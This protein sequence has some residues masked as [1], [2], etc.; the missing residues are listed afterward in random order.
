M[1]TEASNPSPPAEFDLTRI[2]I[3]DGAICLGL[4]KHEGQPDVLV[5]ASS[6]HREVRVNLASQG[7]GRMV[8]SYVVHDPK[9]HAVY[10]YQGYHGDPAKDRLVDVT[11]HR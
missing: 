5:F 7:G 1:T 9:S 2:P 3:L 8:F 11:T 4:F 10:T 6:K